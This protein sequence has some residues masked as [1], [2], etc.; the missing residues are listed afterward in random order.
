MRMASLLFIFI[1]KKTEKKITK[2]MCKLLCV[3]WE[4]LKM[5]KNK[6][7]K[8]TEDV[9]QTVECGQEEE[10]KEGGG[11]IWLMR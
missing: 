1:V 11:G 3:L 4:K 8:V 5:E 9:V 2:K 6:N 7:K 10:E